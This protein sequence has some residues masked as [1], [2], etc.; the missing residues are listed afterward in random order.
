MR[1]H[2]GFRFRWKLFYT[3]VYKGHD[4]LYSTLENFSST[5]VYER[6]FMDS[7]LIA[8][9]SYLAISGQMRQPVMLLALYPTFAIA[10]FV[11]SI[12]SMTRDKGTIYNLKK[13]GLK[14][15]KVGRSSSKSTSYIGVNPCPTPG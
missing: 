11:T 6:A 10:P 5:W 7:C 3:F 13:K 1:D 2:N 15:F 14:R 9:Y 8:L 4:T 12:K